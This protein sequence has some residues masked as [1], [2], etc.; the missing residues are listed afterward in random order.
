MQAPAAV[1]ATQTKLLDAAEELML[2][3][4]Y[5]ATSVDAI[6]AAAGVTK[7]SF[8]HYF[9]QKEDLGKV[10]LKRFAERQGARFMAA[11]ETIEDPLERVHAI[12]DCGVA[13]MQ[14]PESKGCLVGAL[15]Q[16]IWDTHPELRELCHGTFTQFTALLSADLVAAKARHC[17]DAAFDAAGLGDYFLSVAQGSMLLFRAGGERAAMARN[18]THFRDYLRLLYG[19]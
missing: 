19:R 3:R 8:F 17:P 10:L 15:A 4:G 14:A 18:L 13:S 12:M 1:P 16:E 11:A 6:C 7:G 9:A 5:G 2:T